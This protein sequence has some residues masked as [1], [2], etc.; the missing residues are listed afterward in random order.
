[1]GAPAHG[2]A[3]T[4]RS[5]RRSPTPPTCSIRIPATISNALF[6]RDEVPA[7]HHPQ[8]AGGGLDPVPGARLVRARQGHADNTHDLPL[9]DNDSWFERP[10]RVPKTPADPPKVANSTRPPAYVNNN[11]HWWDGS[12]VYG[13]TQG[14][15]G[16]FCATGRGGKVRVQDDGRLFHDETTGH[17]DHR[18]PRQPVGGAE[19]AAQPVRARAQRH[20][21]HVHAG[22]LRL[23]RRAAVPAGAPR[24]LGADGE[25]PHHRVD[26]GDPAASAAGAGAQHQL[27]GAAAGAAEGVSRPRRQRSAQ[28]HS[29]LADRPSH[30]AVLAH[31]GVRLGLPHALADAGRLRDPLG[32][33]R[34]AARLVR[35]AGD[36]G[37]RRP[38]GDREVR[39]RRSASTRWASRI[40]ARCGCT[41]SRSTCRTCTRT[42]PAS[43]ST[44]PPWT[45]CATASAACRATTSSAA[46]S[47]SRRSRRS[48]SSATTR[49]GPRRSSGS[50]AATSRRWIC[51]WA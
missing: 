45:S 5:P 25:D 31:R 35:A 7:G 39:L 4:S 34:Q 40:P 24:Q 20:L 49:N 38:E 46:C 44:S 9:A 19:P 48:R 14:R 26:A 23:E 43:A 28:R 11:S 17:R 3:A 15:A 41:T 8:R 51:W 21:R 16:R 30:G 29:R 10:M 27:D 47:T 13:S 42:P 37:P 2:S 6:T 32:Q 33:G 12:K 18:Q 50:T 1:M 22:A 36:V